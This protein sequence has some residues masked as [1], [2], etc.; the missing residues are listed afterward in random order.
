VRKWEKK[1]DTTGAYAKYTW[2]PC[3]LVQTR[4]FVPL[5]DI[6]ATVQASMSSAMLL[7]TRSA[8]SLAEKR[9]VELSLRDQQRAP[10]NGHGDNKNNNNNNNNNNINNNNNGDDDDDDADESRSK[11]RRKAAE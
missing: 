8:L 1:W 2:F 4:K 9:A 10:T 5:G 6:D 3:T 7:R 11:R